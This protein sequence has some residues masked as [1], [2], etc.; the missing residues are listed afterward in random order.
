MELAR[1]HQLRLPA[2][3]VAQPRG[4]RRRRAAGGACL[5]F[6][7]GPEPVE[8]GLGKT[9]GKHCSQ[10]PARWPI[11]DID[12]PRLFLFGHGEAGLARD[13][14]AERHALYRAR[15]RLAIVASRNEEFQ[16]R[17]LRQR[18]DHAHQLFPLRRQQP[19]AAGI[20]SD[21]AQ[22]V[23]CAAAKQLRQRAERRGD[24]IA[25]EMPDRFPDQR[26]QAEL[27][28]V[29]VAF[30]RYLQGY[31]AVRILQ[32]VDCELEWQLERVRA[33][34][35]LAQ[36]EL[37]QRDLVVAFDHAVA[38]AVIEVQPEAPGGDAVAGKAHRIGRCRDQVDI[39]QLHPERA[40]VARR[41]RIDGSGEARIA[42]FVDA[43]FERELAARLGVA[44]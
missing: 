8:L 7:F 38:H 44:G 25:D 41:K 2:G 3:E 43:A 31:P 6:R 27:R 12:L 17:A 23:P 30:D 42:E 21:R 22:V 35:A 36:R 16:L 20:E 1:I 24:D 13:V 32:Q 19:R 33:V 34:D 4:H 29:E 39:A 28:V 26:R 10:G 11:F 18:F 9:L 14:P 15:I 40:A 37:L 5:G